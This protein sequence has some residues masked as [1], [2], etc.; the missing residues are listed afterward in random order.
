MLIFIVASILT[1]L[2]AF[3]K[4][5]KFIKLKFSLFFSY[6]TRL[7]TLYINDSFVKK[8][9]KA[10]ER[11]FVFVVIIVNKIIKNSLF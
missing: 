4:L 8:I 7:A 5:I 3:N 1:L 9:F 11:T 6:V 2:I 10:F